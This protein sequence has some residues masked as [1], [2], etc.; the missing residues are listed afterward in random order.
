MRILVKESYKGISQ[1]KS[2][3]APQITWDRVGTFDTNFLKRFFKTLKETKVEAL[4]VHLEGE[5]VILEYP[6]GIFRLESQPVRGKVH[7]WKPWFD[8]GGTPE[9][10]ET[11]IEDRSTPEFKRAQFR[12]IVG[13]A[14]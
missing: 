1:F 11:E 3:D 12:V 2:S 5:T 4:D 10:N 9:C 7:S 13:G 8:L 14:A 6:R